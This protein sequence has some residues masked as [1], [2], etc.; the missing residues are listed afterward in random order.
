MDEFT[1]DDVDYADS[2]DYS[3]ELY[4]VT[5]DVMEYQQ[6]HLPDVESSFDPDNI[7]CMKLDPT[8]E[9]VNYEDEFDDL[10]DPRLYSVDVQMLLTWVFIFIYARH[11]DNTHPFFNYERYVRFVD[12]DSVAYQSAIDAAW[13]TLQAVDVANEPLKLVEILGP[14]FSSDPAI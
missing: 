3:G 11:D 1:A 10:P 4:D 6:Q 13:G 2:Q 8:I 9:G 14:Q 5:Q 7:F 12:P